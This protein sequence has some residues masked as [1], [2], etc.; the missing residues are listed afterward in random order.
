MS[1]RGTGD[2]QPPDPSRS[3]RQNIPPPLSFWCKDPKSH[4]ARGYLKRARFF[5][6][7]QTAGSPDPEEKLVGSWVAA[8]SFKTGKGKK[9]AT[10]RKKPRQPPKTFESQPFDAWRYCRLQALCST[11]ARVGYFPTGS[12][13]NSAIEG[14]CGTSAVFCAIVLASAGLTSLTEY[15]SVSP[16]NH[17]RSDLMQMQLHSAIRGTLR[18]STRE[19]KI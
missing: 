13:S 9:R 4:A 15:R 8:H 3:T 2:C 6:R 7:C 5:G 19:E 12:S 16:R 18:R 14:T 10:R 17:Y 1:P 11:A